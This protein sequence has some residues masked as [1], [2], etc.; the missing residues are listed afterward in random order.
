MEQLQSALKRL[1]HFSGLDG[2]DVQSERLGGLT[3]LVFKL[4][5]SGRTYLLRIPG[6][7]TGD[8]IDRSIEGHN[9][10]VA[11]RAGVS[12][13][14]LFFDEADGLMLAD[15]IEGCVTMTPESFPVT[16]GAPGRAALAM[17]QMHDCGEDFRF[18][19][20]LFAMIEDYLSVLDKL[21]AELPPGYHDVVA[22]AAEIRTVLD[23][24]PVDLKPCHCDPLCEN[25]LDD[26]K[27]MWI[28]DWEYSG[29]N[30]PYWDLG[31]LS[32]EACFGPEQDREMM[33][34]YCG[35]AVPNHLM[36]RM[37]IYKA[38]CDLLWTLWGLIQHANKNP[39]DDFWAYAI[40]RFERCKA[41]MADPGF[42]AHVDAVKNGPDA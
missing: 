28:V 13:Q 17:K 4:T 31:D 32:V 7:G 18:R 24:K 15:Y 22:E 21:G 6:E 33:E 20:E 26:G 11:A 9:A 1:S 5:T 34:A 41:L 25:F 16:D 37:V 2:N 30:D 29:M 8:Y 14:V 10:Q 19:F 39:A 35:G 27:R 38:M 3:N 40:N 36:G 12:A 23:A 42:A